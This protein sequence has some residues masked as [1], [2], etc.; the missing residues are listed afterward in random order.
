MKISFLKNIVRNHYAIFH[1]FQINPLWLTRQQVP[2]GYQNTTYILIY[3]KIIMWIF[4]RFKNEP[5]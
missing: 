1:P 5:V 3:D 2:V 4:G